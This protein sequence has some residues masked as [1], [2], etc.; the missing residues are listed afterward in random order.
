MKIIKIGA[1]WCPGCLIMKK[2]WN[3]IL[4]DYNLN[5]IELDYDMDNVDGSNK[6]GIPFWPHYIKGNKMY[7]LIG[8]EEFIE[9][10]ASCESAQ[11]KQLAAGLTSESN[12][13]LMIVTL[14]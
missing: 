13:V 2:V 1:I 11:I 14:K 9:H 12:P 8:A 7:Q 10:A 3:N 4:K 5:I 6:G